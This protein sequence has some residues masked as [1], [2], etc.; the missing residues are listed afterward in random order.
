MSG[1]GNRRVKCLPVS[2]IVRSD[3]FIYSANGETADAPVSEMTP[4]EKIAANQFARLIDL[5]RAVRQ[6]ETLAALQFTI[7]NDMRRLVPYRQATLLLRRGKR[8][9]TEALS[10]IPT[11]DR[12]SPFV[13]W[14]ERV[15][16]HVEKTGRHHEIHAVDPEGLDRLA[17]TAWR[18]YCPETLV[19]I[20]L[21]AAQH[22]SLGGLVVAAES[23]PAAHQ[24]VLLEHLAATFAHALQVFR[25][26]DGLKS[27]LVGRPRR[28]L[29]YLAGALAVFALV[30]RVHLTALAMAEIVPRQPFMVTSPLNGVVQK[31]AVQTNEAVQ[32]GDRLVVLDDT[33]LRNRY[34]LAEKALAVARAEYARAR[35]GAFSD[36][37][38]QAVLAELEAQVAQRRGEVTFAKDKLARAT[39]VADRA[40]VAIT[41]PSEEW[42]GRP[43]RLGEA[44]MQ[45]AD[46]R[47]VEARILLPVKDAVL[48]GTGSRI[49]LFLDSAPLHPLGASV[50]RTEYMPE[51][52]PAGYFAYRIF[53]RLEES[54]PPPRIG[55]RGTAK[56]YGP[57]VS[58]FFYLFRRPLTH[59]R[60][61]T[62]W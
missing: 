42:E 41:P 56:V 29:V 62:G 43:V 16:R 37:R 22:G 44:I 20:P 49:R 38:S 27:A 28:L 48:L 34:E 35:R 1:S 24:M 54:G 46:P 14:L 7:V 10:D 8:L 17:Q 4:K 45:I 58:L 21:S 33:E 53:A 12:A 13:Q 30:Y 19:W 5:E 50:V 39:L 40:G 32:P 23:P 59:V 55:L 61:M 47:Q 3:H 9:R 2:G 18:E 6:A 57:E 52:T 36:K 51:A 25:P 26:A 31:I 11:V 15:A 60:Q